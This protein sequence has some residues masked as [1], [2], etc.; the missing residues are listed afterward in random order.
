MLERLLKTL[1][2]T[3]VLVS[4]PLTRRRLEILK[5]VYEIY[6]SMLR[7][8][9]DYA[10]SKNIASW[11]S[12][13]KELYKYFREKHKELP[14]HYI[15]EAIRDASTRLKSFLK[16]KKRGSA[17]TEKPEVRKWSVGCDNQLWRL[18]IEGV[19]IATHRGWIKIPLLFHKHF[20]K[21]YNSGWVLRSS[22]RWRLEGDRFKLYVV[23]VK[24]V[25]ERQNYSKVV[26]VDVNENNVTLFILP[27]MKAYTIVTNHS[28]IV[29]GYSYRRISLQLKYGNGSRALKRGFR[30]LRERFVKRD[31][32]FKV[33][34][35]VAKIALE[36]NAVVALEKLPKKFQDKM[37]ERNRLKSLDAHRLEQSAIRGLQKAIVEKLQE[38]SI[39]IVF[40]DPKKTSSKCPICGSP[41]T[42]VTSDA[43]RSGWRPRIVKCAKCGFTHDRDVIG[44]WNIALK[45][46]VS[47]VP[48]G[49]KG[50]H[51]PRVEWSVTT[52][53]R[54]RRGTICPSETYNDLGQKTASHRSCHDF[55]AR[56]TR[57][58]CHRISSSR[59]AEIS[60]AI[61][62]ISMDPRVRRSGG[63]ER[64]RV[65]TEILSLP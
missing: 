62:R 8:A 3:V 31:L 57:S 18:S 6:G 45:V 38:N 15:H 41:L 21:Y 20:L 16:L 46:D 25:G 48:L 35:I 58:G 27:E 33:A 44:A 52:V 5:H 40:V 28:K 32:R 42:P 63:S 13:K 4:P 14:S 2:R 9:L 17:Y 61:H 56:D 60:Q 19:S 36:N 59:Y 47:L 54:G 24:E 49:S 37:I 34:N 1:T 51:D 26:G 50:A 11:M 23:F 10:H 43:Q 64:Q 30:R 29:L 39:K 22:C 7:E 55:K 12:V 53:K 65:S